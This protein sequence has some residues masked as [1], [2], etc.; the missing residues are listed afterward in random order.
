MQ[1]HRYSFEVEPSP[2][3][4][5]PIFWN[6][7]T[8]HVLEHSNLR[9]ETPHDGDGNGEG[10]TRYSHFPVQKYLLCAGKAASRAWLTEVEPW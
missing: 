5:E 2:E 6:K 4:L 10:L 7:P 1:D 8:G 3:G 9:I